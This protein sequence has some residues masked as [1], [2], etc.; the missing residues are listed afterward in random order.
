MCNFFAID[1]YVC[2]MDGTLAGLRLLCLVCSS[3]LGI[4]L[5]VVVFVFV[6]AVVSFCFV[7]VCLFVCCCCCCCCFALGFV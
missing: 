2:W 3:A 6:V 7:F 4:F 5:V 1:V